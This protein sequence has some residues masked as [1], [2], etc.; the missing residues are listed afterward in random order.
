MVIGSSG[1]PAPVISCMI[2][3]PIDVTRSDACTCL[4][5]ISGLGGC[6][7]TVPSHEP[8]KVFSLSKDFCASDGCAP[9]IFSSIWAKASIDT[10]IRAATNIHRR[11]FMFYSPQSL[12]RAFAYPLGWKAITCDPQC[13]S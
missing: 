3:F 12:S 6:V 10:D 1:L 8:A 11:D 9:D 4:L 7:L 5:S 13:Y 2:A